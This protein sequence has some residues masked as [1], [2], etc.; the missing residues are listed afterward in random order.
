MCEGSAGARE[1][2]RMLLARTK[3]CTRLLL[4]PSAV[5]R[6][7]LEADER[8]LILVQD[9][10]LH[11]RHAALCCVETALPG[12]CAMHTLR[13]LVGASQ[14]RRRSRLADQPRVC[15]ALLHETLKLTD[16][17]L[18]GAEKQMK[19]FWKTVGVEGRPEG[20]SRRRIA[21]S[22]RLTSSTPLAQAS[23]PSCSTNGR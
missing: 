3:S 8:S 12:C 22:A 15:H 7:V 18:T 17:Q 5:S 19:R 14:C 16:F 23:S 9:R 2:V 6:R 4:P 10:H 21:H 20:A 11:S 1:R 13:E